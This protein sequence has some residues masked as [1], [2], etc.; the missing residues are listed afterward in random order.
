MTLVEEI[1]NVHSSRYD[2]AYSE[3]VDSGLTL[4][5]VAK[6]TG[7]PISTIKKWSSEN[8]W[9]ADKKDRQGF[10]QRVT[11][12]MMKAEKALSKLAERGD[13]NA[14]HAIMKLKKEIRQDYDPNKLLAE[15]GVTLVTMIENDGHP[16]TATIVASYLQ[17]AAD[18]VIG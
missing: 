18:K 2:Q 6:S 16:E 12:S 10:A 14:L 4:E 1:C 11:R 5:Q 13:V 3:Y 7:V 15:F 8:D 17:P 9:Y